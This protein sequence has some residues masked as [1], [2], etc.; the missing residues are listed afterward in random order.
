MREIFKLTWRLLVIAVVAA[1]AL[2]ATN[3]LTKGPIREQVAAAA[4][5]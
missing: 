5:A 1:F 2:G 4:D 3:E